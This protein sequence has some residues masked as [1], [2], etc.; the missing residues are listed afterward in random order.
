MLK[1]VLLV[2]PLLFACKG[3]KSDGKATKSDKP[4]QKSGGVDGVF[5]GTVVTLP[6]EVA[7]VKFGSKKSEATKIVGDTYA[8]SKGKA[9]I[10][11]K[12][13]FDKDNNLEKLTVE[14][15]TDLLP[16]LT[17]QWG[18]P[19]KNADEEF[20]WF[21]PDTGLRA[22]LPKYGKGQWVTFSEYQSLEKL[23]GASGFEPA[24]AKGKKLFG[25]TLDEAKADWGAALCDFDEKA[26]EM[27]KA[28][29]E[30][31]KDSI[32]RLEDHDRNLRFCHPPRG[33]DQYNTNSDTL[34]VGLDL[35]INTLLV[36]VPTGKSPE[37]VK[38]TVE[39][40]DKKFGGKPVEVKHSDSTSRF[41][42]DPATKLRAE[43]IPSLDWVTLRMSPYMPVKDLIGPEGLTV[44][45][46]HM[47]GGTFEE[48]KA[49]DPTHF[50]QHGELAVLYYPSTEYGGQHTEIELNAMA[51]EKKI[52]E[53]RTVIHFTDNDAAGDEMFELMK[54]AWGEPKKDSRTTEKD[55]Y[56]NFKTKTRKISARRVSQ[57]WQISVSK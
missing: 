43:V 45:T 2:L 18:A 40:L 28:F 5:T 49:D 56:W 16:V 54:T 25:A 55:L 19:I 42:F 39:F 6:A 11:Y 10:A 44:A 53:Y 8:V 34:W 22:W 1:R 12:L 27:K 46:A 32:A 7:G 20:F 38:Q 15:H 24:F 52:S 31:A 50:Q 57:Q 37:I 23:L 29:D 48:I 47:P 36:T 3:D 9:D 51:H 21:A 30:Y 4:A 35:K 41:Y 14:S 26:P 17:K 33:L 13:D